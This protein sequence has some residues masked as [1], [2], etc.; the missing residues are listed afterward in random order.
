M[1]LV[2]LIWKS[3][4]RNK[5]RMAFTI[6]TVAL[7]FFVLSI[8]CTFV[9]EIDRAISE[10][11]PTRM[12]T[13]NTMGIPNVLPE[14]YRAA[15]E[16]VPGVAALTPLTTP[17]A[18]YIDPKHTDFEQLACDPQALFAVM[19]ELK[20]PPDQKAAFL[21]DRTGVIVG[22]QKAKKHDW[23]VGDHMML[24]A[25]IYPVNLDLTIRGIYDA[26]ALSESVVYF[27][28]EY[29]EEA[30]GRPGIA[31]AYWVRAVSP[32]A[33][34]GVMKAIDALFHDS[35]PRT[36][37]E[38]E[39]ANR[40]SFVGMMGNVKALIA[41]LGTVI[42]VT[43][44]IITAS[45]IAMSVR[46]RTR[47]IAI[48]K[49]LGFRRDRVLGMLIAEGVTMMLAG[50]LVGCLGARLLF[51]FVEVAPYTQN[52]F[53]RFEVTWG[54]VALGLALTSVVGLFSAGLPAYQA[55]KRR[56]ADGLRHV[57]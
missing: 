23:K 4:T 48:L 7:A 12:L 34:P 25:G 30:A 44:L 50:G 45:S 41:A 57:G 14:R 36:R 53:Q 46:E 6:I 19:P 3:G 52:I 21:A 22:R 18:V 51:S 9:N 10:A 17:I 24:E 39:K 29:L 49:A 11:D 35:D 13:R 33:V 2:G 54:I 1:S 40:L 26:T 47:E 5:R 56:V 38:T 15:I 8:L 43:I 16:K 28:D 20:L 37:T 31:H 27:H 32:D 42:L 55:T